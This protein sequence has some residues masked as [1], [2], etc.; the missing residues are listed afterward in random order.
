MGLEGFKQAN[1]CELLELAEMA[2]QQ[3]ARDQS[4]DE[5][6]LRAIAQAEK[7]FGVSRA[8]FSPAQQDFAEA[9]QRRGAGTSRRRQ[10]QVGHPALGSATGRFRMAR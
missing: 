6:Q 5:R 4:G 9:M 7:G 8:D 10:G 3:E 1:F 2:Q